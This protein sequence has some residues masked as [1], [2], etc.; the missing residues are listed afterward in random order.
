MFRNPKN[1]AGQIEGSDPGNEI[2]SYNLNMAIRNVRTLLRAGTPKNLTQNLKKY[3]IKSIKSVLLLYKKYGGRGMIHLIMMIILY[4]RV[5]V[6]IG[7]S[8]EQAF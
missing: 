7:I 5:V 4:A 8:L 3:K 1:Y 2:M 6:M